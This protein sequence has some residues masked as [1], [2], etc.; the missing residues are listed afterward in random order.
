MSLDHVD[1]L[2]VGAGLSGIGAAYHLQSN[3][4]GKSYAILEARESIGG[5][6]D[7]FKYPGIRSDSD[8]YTL[9]YSFKPWRQAKA[10]ADGPSILDYVRETARDNHIQEKI[11]FHHRV[12]R[13]RWSSAEA[14]WT[15]QAFRSDTQETVQISCDFVFMC[16]G[17]YRY[18]EG[19][20]PD[21]QGTERFAGE[22]VHPQ[23]WPE[24]LDYAGKR[25][26]VIGSGATAVTLVPTLA[27]DAEHVTMLQRSPSYVVSRPEQDMIANMLRGALPT[28]V[29]YAIVR[30]KNVL[31][32]MAS[33]QLSR[34]RPAAMKALLYK[35]LQKQLPEGYDIDTHFKPSYNPWDQRLCLVPD[36]DLFKSIHS[37]RASVVTDHIDTF[38]E[39]G[40]K[41][42]SGSEIEAEVIVTAT[43]LNLLVL[44]GMQIEIDGE[45]IELSRTMAYKGMMLSGVPNLALAIGY[46]NASWTLKCDLTCEYVCRLL[47]HM[48]EH[49]YRYC[50]PR[51]SDPSVTEQPFLDFSSGYVLRSI[52]KFPKQG[53]RAP[54]RL[55]QNYALDILSLKFGS[56]EDGALEFSTALAAAQE[57]EALA[58]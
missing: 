35:A 3:C 4:P 52:D 18:D 56:L 39:R 17:Y 12:V 49:G 47:G 19:Y 11:R 43:G 10:I 6:W 24:D 9:G 13:A 31:L 44:G 21:F 5:T 15:V 23:H 27:R 41:L 33:F 25:V 57:K 54:W 2:I 42:T 58:V 8:M 48:D 38:T 1:V 34:R 37:G 53:S 26:V 50:T 40:L 20:T 55:H 46:T 36:G 16:S 7:L 29:A 45:E 51:N 28:K 14:R 30:W 32:T 22:I